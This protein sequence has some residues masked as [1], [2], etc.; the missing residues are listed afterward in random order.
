[1]AVCFR[2]LVPKGWS[3]VDPRSANVRDK[4]HNAGGRSA[5]ESLGFLS[6]NK[7]DVLRLGS[8]CIPPPAGIG[9]HLVAAVAWHGK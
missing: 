1:M 5:N 6:T 3:V 4:G 2:I 7:D 8:L 9:A